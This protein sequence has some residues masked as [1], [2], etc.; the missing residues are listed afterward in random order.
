MVSKILTKYFK[1][2]G[3]GFTE[4][5]VKLLVLGRP[6]HSLF[7][8]DI[9]LAMKCESFINHCQAYRMFSKSLMKYLKGCSIGFTELHAK[10]DAD[11]LLN[12]AIHRRQEKT[13]SQ[14]A[15]V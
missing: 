10:F 5:H 1:G 3:S 6:E 11:T 7:S 14:K 2:C 9:W 12:F 13:W 8:A 15:L 4:L